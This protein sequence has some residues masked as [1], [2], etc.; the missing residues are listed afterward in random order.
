MAAHSR[1]PLWRDAKAIEG[2]IRPHY[3]PELPYHNFDHP[4]DVRRHAFI[5]A[6]FAMMN[7]V[8]I[9]TDILN[10]ASLGHD[11]ERDK[12]P[13][14]DH[15][16]ATPEDYAAKIMR[17]IMIDY[18]NAPADIVAGTD[19]AIR[20]TAITAPCE[21]DTEI[22]LFRGD[23]HNLEESEINFLG[24]TFRLFRE[25]KY[26]NHEPSPLET[27]SEDRLMRVFRDYAVKQR[28]PLELIL[29]KDRPLGDYEAT[30]IGESIFTVNARQ[31]VN[32]LTRPKLD[33]IL[34]ELMPQIIARQS[35]RQPD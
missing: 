16:S 28:E 3:K 15:T 24:V 7:G 29:K 33:A 20:S 2:F 5:V 23:V 6:N 30:S 27:Y 21:T 17:K 35:Q 22:C 8:E 11:A 10:A 14:V 34:P 18:L 12:I 9:Q 25:E 26:L 4:L 19:R 31:N 32:L 1:L 13:E